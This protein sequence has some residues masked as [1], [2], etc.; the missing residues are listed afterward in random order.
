MIETERGN[1][2]NM[3]NRTINGITMLC[4]FLITSLVSCKKDDISLQS[5]NAV[6]DTESFENP[7]FDVEP[8]LVDNPYSADA[9]ASA[10]TVSMDA[11]ATA[12]YV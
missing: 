7:T 10:N 9:S 2:I 1:S 11:T 6:E 8:T 12:T 5:D 3:K 4:F